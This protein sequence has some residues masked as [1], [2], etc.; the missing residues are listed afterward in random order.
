MKQITIKTGIHT[1][2]I[3]ILFFNVLLVNGQTANFTQVVLPIGHNVSPGGSVVYKS[4]LYLTMVSTDSIGLLYKFDGTNFTEINFPTGYQAS[5]F[6]SGLIVYNNNMY[7]IAD[8]TDSSGL[9]FRYDGTNFTEINFPTGYHASEQTSGLIVYNN[10]MYL[11]ADGTDSSGLLFRY[12]GTNFTKI[13]FPTGYQ[14]LGSLQVYNNNMYLTVQGTDSTGLLF[15]YD[16]TTLT[17]INLPATYSSMEG[18]VVYNN[19]LYLNMAGYDSIGLLFKYDGSTFTQIKLPTGYKTSGSFQ[20]FNNFL[21]LTMDS[22]SSIGLLFKYDGTTFTQIKLPANFQVAT[23]NM[24]NQN[25]P[26]YT[27]MS[28]IS[29]PI[30]KNTMYLNINETNVNN[31]LGLL[32]TVFFSS[33][34]Q[35]LSGNIA[36]PI[37]KKVNGVTVAMKGTDT[38]VTYT[39]SNGDYTD[40]LVNGENYTLT[41]YKNNDINKTNGV[42][43]IDL[44]LTQSH[45]LGKNLLNSPYKIIAADVN[46]DGKVSTL[47]LVYMKRLILG[48]DT[49]FT[50][51]VTKENRL[52]AFIDSSYQFADTTNPFPFKD[53][54]SYTGLNANQ[55]NQTFI[56]VKLGDVNW[57]WNPAI[58]RMPSPVFVSPKKLSVG[59]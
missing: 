6:A 45:I 25:P 38:I 24:N 40:S 43:S 29:M 26:D 12:D 34:I 58:A 39:N 13:N 16:G 2:L 44:A 59:Q 9:L 8:G 21:F 33:V 37:G 10:N 27:Q 31:G 53:S 55:T 41:P 56:G 48:L 28:F 17:K 23:S 46:G 57:D 7:L 18:L 49:T 4:N 42:T 15:K 52:W 3:I 22:D 54:I 20:V 50:N 47:D 51:S 36:T 19:N 14:S 5:Q 32:F 30:F 35:T 1:I 11:I